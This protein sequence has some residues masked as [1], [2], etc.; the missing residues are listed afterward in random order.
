MLVCHHNSRLKAKFL[1]L[2]GPYDELGPNGACVDLR[3]FY[4]LKLT[5][6]NERKF[7]ITSTYLLHEV[8]VMGDFVPQH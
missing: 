4:P 1:S 3:N 6:S 7:Y 2:F 5:I 8:I